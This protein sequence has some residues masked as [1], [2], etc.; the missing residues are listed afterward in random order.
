M[1]SEYENSC[2]SCGELRLTDPYQGKFRCVRK[3]EDH[4]AFDKKCEKYYLCRKRSNSEIESAYK[5][6]KEYSKDTSGCYLTTMI[7]NIL[8][9]DDSCY[10]LNILRKFRERNKYNPYYQYLFLIYDI[11]GPLI[12]KKL[13]EDFNRKSV[14]IDMITNYINEAC[15]NIIDNNDENAKK[16]YI[17]MTNYLASLYGITISYDCLPS[18]FNIDKLGHGRF[19]SLN[20]I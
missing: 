15:L 6:S 1:K 16:L 11:Y 19:L 5:Y 20:M 2:V 13:S 14:A 17:D 12:A 8:G 10:Y 3:Y 18:E 9:Y 7:C 4:Y